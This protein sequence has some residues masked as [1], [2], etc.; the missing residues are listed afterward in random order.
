MRLHWASTVWLK[1]LL[2]HLSWYLFSFSSWVSSFG[3]CR[4]CC[5]KP[6]EFEGIKIKIEI[7]GWW[8][9][10]GGGPSVGMR[11]GRTAEDIWSRMGRKGKGWLGIA[12]RLLR[13]WL[14]D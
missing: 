8:G 1:F 6:G 11:E 7:G 13:L 14:H 9:G 5:F 10:A 3:G 2:L 4:T 12:S